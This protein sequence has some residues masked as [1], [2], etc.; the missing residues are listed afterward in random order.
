MTCR[1]DGTWPEIPERKTTDQLKPHFKVSKNYKGGNPAV[2][3]GS[4]ILGAD[5]KTQCHKEKTHDEANGICASV[6]SRLCTSAEIL[7]KATQGTGC[8][9]DY[10]LVWTST[11]CTKGYITLKGN[12]GITDREM[13]MPAS[14]SN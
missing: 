5:G 8:R 1:I 6:G 9:F 10:E 2:S 4:M 11:P 12:P 7:A 14:A 3:G 13:C